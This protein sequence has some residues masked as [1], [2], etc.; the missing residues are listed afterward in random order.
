MYFSDRNHKN[1]SNEIG[2]LRIDLA[3]MFYIPDISLW[4]AI[5]KMAII[6]VYLQD[7]IP[8]KISNTLGSFLPTLLMSGLIK[9]A[10]RSCTHHGF[11][12][13]E[14]Q[15]YTVLYWWSLPGRKR[16]KHKRYRVCPVTNNFCQMN[17]DYN[18]RYPREKKTC[19]I[20]KFFF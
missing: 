2:T 7:M 13:P 11:A 19:L 3:R 17:R 15:P 14:P 16:T 18:S 20:P 12:D 10:G 9:E 4:L 1:R 5:L 8:P 6:V